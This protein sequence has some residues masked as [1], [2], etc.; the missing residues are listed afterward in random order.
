MEQIEDGYLVLDTS[1]HIVLS[2]PAANTLLGI[3]IPVSPEKKPLLKWQ[4]DLFELIKFSD[5]EDGEEFSFESQQSPYTINIRVK[6][7]IV[8]EQSLILLILKDTQKLTQQVQQL[9]LAIS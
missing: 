1:N 2:N 5:L 9:K 4:P 6:H 3:H 8:P 7:L